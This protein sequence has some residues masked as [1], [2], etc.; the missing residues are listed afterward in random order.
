MG[1]RGGRLSTTF[2]KDLEGQLVG[3]GGQLSEPVRR[4]RGD[5][6]H[7]DVRVMTCSSLEL[8]GEAFGKREKVK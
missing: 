2:G 8:L 3:V 4:W 5:R 6:V 1:E 7:V